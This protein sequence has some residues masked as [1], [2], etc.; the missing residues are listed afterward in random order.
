MQLAAPGNA[1]SFAIGGWI[2]LSVLQALIGWIVRGFV[3]IPRGY[4]HA[5][6]SVRQSPE[7]SESL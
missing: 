1:F 7:A 3:G 6:E 4:D 2:A 5:P